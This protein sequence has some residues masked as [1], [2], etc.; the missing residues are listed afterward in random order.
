MNRYAQYQQLS[1]TSATRIDLL[2]ALFDGAIDRIDEAR[3]L[4]ETDR[5]D[6]VTAL[7]LRAQMIVLEL[8]AGV[9]PEVQ[10]EMSLN[11]LRL[12]EYV[13][14]CLAGATVERL[15]SASK[16]LSNL[17][18]GFRAIRAEAVE[19]ERRGEISPAESQSVVAALA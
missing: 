9:R 15:R 1:T 7:L 3:S 13:A 14:F 2:L 10:P 12:Y 17:R 18:E 4:I 16:V 8:A 5:R 19:L 11:I 6:R